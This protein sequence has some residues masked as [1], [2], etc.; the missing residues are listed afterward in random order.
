MSTKQKN[1]RTIR[2]KSFTTCTKAC[3]VERENAGNIKI[4]CVNC[5]DRIACMN[6]S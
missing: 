6:E 5:R 2:P 4:S 1:I 3:Y